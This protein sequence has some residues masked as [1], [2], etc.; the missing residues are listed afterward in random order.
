MDQSDGFAASSWKFVR[1]LGNDVPI[2]RGERSEIALDTIEIA[3]ADLNM[4]LFLE[5]SV[6]IE[7]FPF[8]E[9]P[10]HRIVRTLFVLG[11]ESVN[12]LDHGAIERPQE[13]IPFLANRPVLGKLNTGF[14]TGIVQDS[15]PLTQDLQ[16]IRFQQVEA[17]AQIDDRANDRFIFN[18]A[19]SSTGVFFA[20]SGIIKRSKRIVLPKVDPVAEPIVLIFAGFQALA[21]SEHLF[22]EAAVAAMKTADK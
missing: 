10:A 12:G 5:T 19:F 9:D 20:D 4:V 18:P 22:G 6:R 8:P 11:P 16:R 15:V 21:S 3:Y 7:F 2:Y 13:E 17:V 14:R 1:L